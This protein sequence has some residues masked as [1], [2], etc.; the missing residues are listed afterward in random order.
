MLCPEDL[1]EM[2]I[3]IKGTVAIMGEMFPN[4]FF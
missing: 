1:K 4:Q 3:A 2:M